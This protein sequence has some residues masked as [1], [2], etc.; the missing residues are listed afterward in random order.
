MNSMC[1]VASY[2]ASSSSSSPPPHQDSNPRPSPFMSPTTT[3]GA[4][5]RAEVPINLSS[6]LAC[7]SCMGVGGALKR[8][9]RTLKRTF[10][11]RSMNMSLPSNFHTQSF[12]ASLKNDGSCSAC[13]GMCT[14]WK[15]SRLTYTPSLVDPASLPVMTSPT[16]G[17]NTTSLKRTLK[18]AAP[19]LGYTNP[20]SSDCTSYRVTTR[21]RL[22]TT[23][24]RKR[25]WIT[26]VTAS[27]GVLHRSFGSTRIS[28]ST[29]LR[30]NM[31]RL[32]ANRRKLGCHVTKDDQ[33]RW[34]V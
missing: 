25:A 32:R 24:S 30:R 28:S 31:L 23:L 16:N 6:S 2:S 4:K 7:W 10:S 13:S 5:G 22:G 9:E 21:P 17:L 20:P 18:K 8:T 12:S 27:S 15:N 3:M 34:R 14:S 11:P 33:V 19:S 29:T 1:T 26:S